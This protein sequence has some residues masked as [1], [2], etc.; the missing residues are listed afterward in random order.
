MVRPLTHLRDELTFYLLTALLDAY[1]K[2]DLNDE[3]YVKEN[4]VPLVTKLSASVSVCAGNIAALQVK[5]GLS[6][7]KRQVD[8]EAVAEALV[9]LV[10]EVVEA[11]EPL[12]DFLGGISSECST[13]SLS[14]TGKLGDYMLTCIR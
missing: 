11:L 2:G 3:T 13:L 6:L 7:G 5:A 8:Q 12:L 10:A 9:A 1:G 14:P 4:I